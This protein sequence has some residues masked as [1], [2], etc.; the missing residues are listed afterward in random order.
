MSH[1]E[2]HESINII[3]GHVFLAVVQLGLSKCIVHS[4]YVCVCLGVCVCV[5]RCVACV[6]VQLGLS[7]CVYRVSLVWKPHKA[8]RHVCFCACYLRVLL[9]SLMFSI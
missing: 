8:H 9:A 2:E 6:G 7:K 1:P 3:V 4:L 5:G